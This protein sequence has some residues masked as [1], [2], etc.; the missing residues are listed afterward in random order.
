MKRA[1]E[2]S[3]FALSCMF[4][5]LEALQVTNTLDGGYLPVHT[6]QEVV[7]DVLEPLLQLH[8][9]MIIHGDG[10]F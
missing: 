8:K 3:T 2:E 7:F 5:G 9:Q 4:W 1:L 6:V 10:D